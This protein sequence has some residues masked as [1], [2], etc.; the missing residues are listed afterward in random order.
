[1][2]APVHPLVSVLMP[3]LNARAD[4][5][6]EAVESIR[7]QTFADWEL[8]VVEDPSPNLSGTMLQQMNDSRIRHLVNAER[9]SLAQQLNR[10]IAESRGELIARMDA[11]D[12]AAPDRLSAQV[13][14]LRTH[15][16]VTVVGTQIEIIDDDGRPLGYRNYPLGS[17]AIRDALRRF[18]ALAHPAV[19]FRKDEISR[20]GGYRH[21]EFQ[22]AEDYELWCRLAQAGARFA[23]LPQALLRYRIHGGA[24]KKQRFKAMLRNTLRIKRMYWRKQMGFR[25]RMRYY[26]ER[27]LLHLPPRF[28]HWLFRRSQ[29]Q[30][31]LQSAQ[32]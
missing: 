7:G 5:L 2:S 23:N 1:M 14:F 30:K 17:D 3:V 26:A 13:E 24:T 10:G 12:M 21:P 32:S 28:V 22:G 8:V 19:M 6:R 25:D 9:T 27:L 15:P 4:Y 31:K 11:D 29:F 18:N 20:A 16:D